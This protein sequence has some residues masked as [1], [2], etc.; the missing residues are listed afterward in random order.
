MIGGRDCVSVCDLCVCVCV[1][2]FIF[3]FMSE[4]YV[5]SKKSQKKKKLICVFFFFKGWVELG[6]GFRLGP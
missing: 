5:L 4:K 6:H 1:C 2:F 3:F